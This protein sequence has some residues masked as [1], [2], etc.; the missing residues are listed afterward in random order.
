M[1][2]LWQDTSFLLLWPILMDRACVSPRW[3]KIHLWRKADRLQ[4]VEERKLLFVS[5]RATSS[6]KYLLV[7]H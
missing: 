5:C 6:H 1:E 2:K 7:L 4:D 3:D